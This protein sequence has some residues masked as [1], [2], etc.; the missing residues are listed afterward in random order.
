MKWFFAG[1]GAGIAA[2]IMLAPRS[3]AETRESIAESARTAARAGREQLGRIQPEEA[4]NTVREAAGR[5]GE[6]I[7]EAVDENRERLADLLA[8]ASGTD[9]TLNTISR[10][11]LLTVYGIGP[12]LAD[13]IIQGRPYRSADDLLERGILSPST[14]ENLKRELLN[15]RS[16]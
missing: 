7:S 1:L 5:L 11:D 14:V 4:L 12:V 6:R 16:A 13:R 2:G 3:G 8:R 10:D 9:S 15:K